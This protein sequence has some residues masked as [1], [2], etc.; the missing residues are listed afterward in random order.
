MCGDAVTVD[1]RGI[2]AW[3]SS[4]SHVPGAQ[5]VA[6]APADSPGITSS[7]T[8]PGPEVLLQLTLTGHSWSHDLPTG[9][10]CDLN[11]GPKN[12]NRDSQSTFF[13][14]ACTRLC[15]S[16]YSLL[17]ILEA[18]LLNPLWP[19][20]LTRERLCEWGVVD[21]KSRL[22]NLSRRVIEPAL[23][24]RMYSTRQLDTV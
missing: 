9:R 12:R 16:Q 24:W 23:Q 2:V 1:F 10:G 8:A 21:I 13:Q 5:Q 15:C 7:L 18:A 19:K 11:N 22:G 17:A 20:T 3:I 4:S 6:Q 14:V